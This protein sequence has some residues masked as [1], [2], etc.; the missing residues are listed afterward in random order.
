MLLALV[1]AAIEPPRVH[2]EH[3]DRIVF[4][5]TVIHQPQRRGFNAKRNTT[6]HEREMI[7]YRVSPAK[8]HIE[9]DRVDVD[10][11]PDVYRANDRGEIRFHWYDDRKDDIARWRRI[12]TGTGGVLP[13]GI[14]VVSIQRVYGMPVNVCR[15]DL[16][17]GDDQATRPPTKL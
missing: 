13:N 9:V 2:Y 6:R 14:A 1:W 10:R 17:L 11:F 4:S 15:K 16:V 5:T 7:F 3:F 12:H 8:L